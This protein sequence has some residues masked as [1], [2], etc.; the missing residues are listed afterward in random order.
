MRINIKTKLILDYKQ[1]LLLKKNTKT[2]L[3]KSFISLHLLYLYIHVTHEQDQINQY[4][5]HILRVT[6]IFIREKIIDD[7]NRDKFK[8]IVKKVFWF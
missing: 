5:H 3:K 4:L 2:F 8:K 7:R 6:G 1:E